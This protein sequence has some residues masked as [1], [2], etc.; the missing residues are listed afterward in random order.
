M[1]SIVVND[2]KFFGYIKEMLLDFE[3]KRT[4]NNSEVNCLTDKDLQE[5]SSQQLFAEFFSQQNN[6]ELTARQQE[7]VLSVLS[8][9]EAEK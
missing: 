6:Q 9:G 3:N 7:I 1:N 4:Q 8:S 2:K 5:K